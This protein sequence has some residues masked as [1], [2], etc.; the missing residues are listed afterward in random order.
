MYDQL[1]NKQPLP[2][3]IWQD[4]WYFIASCFG[5][6]SLP[7]MPGTYATLVAI[8]FY[9]VMEKY[10]T[11][12]LYL[13]VIVIAFFLFGK[14]SGRVSKEIGVPDHTGLALDEVLGYWVTLFLLP[15][16]WFNIIVGFILFRIF[17][18]WKPL[19][20]GWLD[21]NIESGYGM[22]LDDVMAGIFANI[23]LQ[24]IAIF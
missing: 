21:K 3:K 11:G 24:V 17:D 4:P 8:P 16:T 23:I 1:K 13:L 19:Q 22:M 12:W 2:E 20:I 6:G 7:G 9:L 5:I 10:L 14:L 18:I 15:P